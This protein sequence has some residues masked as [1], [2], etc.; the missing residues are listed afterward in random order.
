MHP[1]AV[2]GVEGAVRHKVVDL[3]G[4]PLAQMA[5]DAVHLDNGGGFGAN[6]NVDLVRL[7]GAAL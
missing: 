7:A 4:V 5:L 3:V 1:V 2:A 6:R